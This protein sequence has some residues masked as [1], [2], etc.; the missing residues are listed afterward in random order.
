MKQPCPFCQSTEVHVV[1]LNVTLSAKGR[2]YVLCYDCGCRGP[3]VEFERHIGVDDQ[4]W[5]EAVRLWNKAPRTV[6][7]GVPDA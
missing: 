4:R 1:R 7:E 2:I 5:H 3:Y 6:P